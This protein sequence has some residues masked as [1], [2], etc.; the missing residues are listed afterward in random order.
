MSKKSKTTETEIQTDA[1]SKVLGRLWVTTAKGIPHRSRSGIK[2]N[3]EHRTEVLVV[4]LDPAEL[5]LKVRAGAAWV[6]RAGA[7]AIAKDDGL[8]AFND[9]GTTAPAAPEL[10]ELE[11]YVAELEADNAKM[12]AEIA[13]LKTRAGAAGG[14]ERLKPADPTPTALPGAGEFGGGRE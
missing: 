6:D 12:K 7:E 1:P 3:A 14:P 10:G 9:P 11:A 5:A 8:N 13:R 4:D 2:F